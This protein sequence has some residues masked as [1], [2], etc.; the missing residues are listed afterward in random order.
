MEELAV[1]LFMIKT[2]SVKNQCLIWHFFMF[3]DFYVFL[4]FY[5]AKLSEALTTLR[6]SF[7][8][9][10]ISLATATYPPTQEII[11]KGR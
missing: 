7:V 2:K 9:F 10:S 1:E 6:L 4:F 11:R 8:L 5:A 3:D